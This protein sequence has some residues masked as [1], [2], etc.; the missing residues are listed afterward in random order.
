[1]Q[2]IYPVKDGWNQ[3]KGQTWLQGQENEASRK[4]SLN[5]MNST[6][7]GT[8]GRP[9]EPVLQYQTSD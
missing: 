9:T 2:Y 1:M 5:L 7:I 8:S 4:M 3:I 6:L